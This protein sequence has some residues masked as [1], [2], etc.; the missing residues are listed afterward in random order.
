MKLIMFNNL[1]TAYLPTKSIHGQLV[2]KCHNRSKKSVQLILELKDVTFNYPGKKPTFKN[3]NIKI[4]KGE[5]LSIVGANGTGKS[6][7][8]KL[9]C[10]FEKPTSGVN[11][12]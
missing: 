9:I 2:F 7:L 4:H 3:V 8:G 5:M 10:G 6:T 11:S 1:N 12:I